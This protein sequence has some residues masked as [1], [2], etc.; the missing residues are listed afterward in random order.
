[1]KLFAGI[2]S[3]NIAE[4]FAGRNTEREEKNVLVDMIKNIYIELTEK[5]NDGR[6]RAVICSGQA[7][8]L[9]R[10]AVMSK[11]GDWIIREEQ[12]S[13]SHITQ[14]LEGYG[15]VYRFGAPLD[16][17][18][19]KEGWSSH[20]E[21][22]QGN[23]RIRTDFF[24]RPP[25]ISSE[26]LEQL[27]NESEGKHP[28]FINKHLLAEM[29]KTN[30]EKDYAVIGEIARRMENPRD[31]FLYSRSARDIIEL[32]GAFPKALEEIKDRR[33]LLTK[34]PCPT[35]ELEKELD[36]ERRK[37][38]HANEERLLK[39]SDASRKWSEKWPEVRSL[40][41][42]RPL[43]ESHAIISKNAEG[44]LPFAP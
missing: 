42:G 31:I 18:W 40:V 1:M 8:V 16:I 36:A 24:T 13:L 39:Y 37:F 25:R 28:P 10:I 7:A 17:R 15:A 20:F 44:V 22:M 32:A 29:K 21:F 41:S 38:M 26:M 43:T 23:L 9:H 5:F 27:W 30:R 4:S 14:I 3:K 19:L 34:L 12:E 2:G 6:L 35:D 11:D 33:E